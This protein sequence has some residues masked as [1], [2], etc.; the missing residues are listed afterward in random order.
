MAAAVWISL[1]FISL[2]PEVWDMHWLGALVVFA[3]ILWVPFLVDWR[4]VKKMDV[5][6]SVMEFYKI[7]K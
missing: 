6:N 2:M 5:V 3:A 1:W 7:K 4:L